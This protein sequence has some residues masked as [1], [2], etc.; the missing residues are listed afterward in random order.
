[1]KIT[2]LETIRSTEHPNLLWLHVHTDDGLVGL[3][4]TFYIPG[5]VES[6]IHDFAAPLLLGY[7]AR[8]WSQRRNDAQAISIWG[9]IVNSYP[10]S[11]EAAESDLEWA[12]TLRR[13]GDL[14]GA[15][16]RFEHLILSFPNSALVPQARRELETLRSDVA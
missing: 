1:M 14:A 10:I 3:G 4:E 8:L 11:P 12:R 7:A 15:T 16:E 9:R 13:K 6:V 5:A 2:R